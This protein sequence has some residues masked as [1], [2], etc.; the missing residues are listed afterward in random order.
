MKSDTQIDASLQQALKAAVRPL[1]N[2]P[3]GQKGYHP[4]SGDRVVDLVH[5][6]LEKINTVNILV[7]LLFPL[8]KLPFCPELEYRTLL[9]VKAKSLKAI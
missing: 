5:V 3:E 8:M 9:I 1:K 4:G 7:N 6:G 2:V